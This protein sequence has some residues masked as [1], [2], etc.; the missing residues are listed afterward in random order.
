MLFQYTK[1]DGLWIVDPERFH[2]A[3]G[4]FG[5]TFCSEEFGALGLST[6]FV[7]HSLSVSLLRHTLRGLHFQVPPHQEAKLV[8]CVRGVIWDVAV[9]LRPGSPTYLEWV[10]TTLSADN[11]RQFYIPEGFAHGFQSLV[12]DVAVSYVISA[13]YVPNSSSGIRYD[14]AAIG[15]DWPARPSV[16]SDKD[17]AWPAWRGLVDL[18]VEEAEV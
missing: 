11:G 9:D 10:G 1:I 5:R 8:S 15:I 2:D 16:M 17:M 7:Q 12:D 13:P 14:D 18:A 3:R 4:S 6:H